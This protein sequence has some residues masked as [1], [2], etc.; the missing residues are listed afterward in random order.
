MAKKRANGEGSIRKRSDGRWEGRYTAGYDPETGKRITKNVLGKTQAEVKE[1]LAKAIEESK[2]LDIVRSDEYT[3]AEWLRLWYELYAKPNIRPTTADNY[4]R[5][6]ESHVIPRIGEIKLKKLT[7]RDIQKMYKDLQENGR[8]RKSQKR[9]KP[10]LSNSTV[11]GIHMMLHNALDRAV[12]ERLILRNPTEDCI[13]PKIQ[14][15]EMKILH[16]E[17]MKAYLEAADKRGVLPMFYLELV[18]GIRKGE[19]TA[20]LWSDLDEERR[21]VSVS[22]QA[23]EDRNR[24]V[25]ISRPKTENSVRKISIPQSAV[26]LLRQEHK[27]HP[28]NPWMFPSPRTGEMYHPDSIAKLHE[29]ILRDTGLEHIRF[30]DLRHTFATMALQNG[31][32]VK[33]VSSMLGHYDAGFTLRTYTHATRQMQEQAAEK[34]G[35]FMERVM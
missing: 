23:V 24:N 32:D 34:M 30:H 12:K 21:T 33:T 26:E 18:T 4:H 17:D 19:L 6:I 29:K 9:E 35:N 20:L 27:N 28:D 1:K 25:T 5:G 22:K 31:V 13:I 2:K 15:Q 14:K 7:S 16:P 10:G 8:L 11:R 3:V